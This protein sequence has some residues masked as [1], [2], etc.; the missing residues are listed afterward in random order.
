MPNPLKP[1]PLQKGDII[2]IISPASPVVPENLAKGIQYLQNCGYSVQLGDHVKDSFGFLAG[3]DI[4][5]LRDLH[6]MFRNPEI[7]AIF[8]SRGGYGTPRLLQELDFDLIRQNPKILMGYSD[9]TAI[10]I[11]IWQ[12][13]GLITFSGPMVAV[14][15]KGIDPFTEKGM[16]SVLT[17]V[18]HKETFP[19][20]S[21]NPLEIIVSGKAQGRLLGGCL[22]VLV[23]LL[24][25]PYQPGFDGAI[26]ILEEVGEEPFRVDR[27]FNQL[28]LA[29]IFD[30]V[31]GVILGQF[32][33]CE[34]EEGKPNFSIS[35]VIYDYFSRLKVPVIGGFLYGHQSRKLTIPIGAL[36]EIDASIPSVRLLEPGVKTNSI[37]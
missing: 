29:G 32:V 9:L 19:V 5:R 7:K 4:E 36:A 8:S 27:Y 37:L 12:K 24:G 34:P 33:D 31:N 26:L 2:G 11:A 6:A 25:T 1:H 3:N 30:Q 14:E 35:E 22:S 13:T 23:S 28:K 16:W 15:M 10:Q 21:N 20:E 18:E 17:A